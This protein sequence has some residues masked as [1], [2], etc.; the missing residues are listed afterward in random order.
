M[1]VENE[2]QASFGEGNVSETAKLIDAWMTS[3]V[4]LNLN[5]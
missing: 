3:K 5:P 4:Y 1:R 2:P